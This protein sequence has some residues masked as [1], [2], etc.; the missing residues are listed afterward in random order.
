MT[1][2]AGRAGAAAAEGG[3]ATAEDSAAAA[4]LRCLLPDPAALGEARRA[5]ETWIRCCADRF[6]A[7]GFTAPTGTWGRT[8][9]PR[10]GA[11]PLFSPIP[12][13]ESAE[14]AAT[15]RFEEE[16]RR[17]ARLLLTDVLAVCAAPPPTGILPSRR[18]AGVVEAVGESD[19]RASRWRAPAGSRPVPLAEAVLAN[20]I[21]GDAS[22]LHSGPECVSA[23]V[24]VAEALDRPLADLLD[25]IAVGCALGDRQRTEVG[26]RMERLGVHAPGAL[27]P[28][29]SAAAVARLLR[30]DP[31]ATAARLA[32][33]EALAPLH[34]YR[35]F[36]QGAPVKLLYGAWGQCLGLWAALRAPNPA[37]RLSIPPP[38]STGEG[39]RGGAA[40]FDDSAN[41]VRRLAFK[42]YPGSR[43]IQPVL[44]AIERLPRLRPT[45]IRSVSVE[46]YPFAAAISSWAEPE[47]GPIAR[48]MHLPTAAAL[49]FLARSAGR[50]FD[51]SDYASRPDAATALATRITVRS[52]DFG[53]SGSH[54]VRRARVL[55]RLRDGTE[56]AA[57]SGAPCDPPTEA[58]VR[59]RFRR[60]T[61]DTRLRDPHELPPDAPVRALFREDA[62]TTAR[63]KI[64]AA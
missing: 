53:D 31:E 12:W 29:A 60:S 18:E 3:A 32:A 1:A 63:R 54:R 61:A 11:E 26:R 10:P 27:A 40:W 55:V 37:G 28:V 45:Q 39:R 15:A 20:R 56:A 19:L 25:A 30:L 58:A 9:E 8:P 46:A 50:E 23:A 5:V 21:A 43:A 41:A 34:P 44:A 51:A 36:A 17:A 52:R 13:T 33:A 7:A 48:Q 64:P 16:D 59:A 38:P 24:A 2:T 47:R 49:L 22:E 35:A 14:W 57:E 6:A 62:A 4:V 42:R